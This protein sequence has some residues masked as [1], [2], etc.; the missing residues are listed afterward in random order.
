MAP[1]KQDYNRLIAQVRT[2]MP[3]LTDAIVRQQFF[4]VM[5]DFFRHTKMWQE[6][7]AISVVPNVVT[8]DLISAEP[9]VF[10]SFAGLTDAAGQPV[11]AT[12]PNLVQVT[13]RFKVNTAQT[14]TAVMIKT[15]GSP[16]D[17]TGLP[18]IPTWVIQNVGDAIFHGTC[19]KLMMQPHKPYS[20][21][22]QGK[23]HGEMYKQLRGH[24]RQLVFHQNTFGAQ[25]WVYPQSY[26]TNGQ[27]GGTSTTGFGFTQ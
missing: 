20:D 7:I 1:Q 12:A 13:L 9:G 10:E 26:Q 11:Q 14:M 21:P 2:E 16:I 4:P 27:R 25:S 17:R 8:Y 23:Y 19:E 15:V 22:V 18:E 3:G 24:F 5:K 6:S